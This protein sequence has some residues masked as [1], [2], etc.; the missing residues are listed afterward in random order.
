MT[1]CCGK[2]KIENLRQDAE[3]VDPA[4]QIK[5]VVENGEQGKD[6][7][8]SE[9]LTAWIW[10]WLCA[11]IMSLPFLAWMARILGRP[12]RRSAGPNIIDT[13]AAQC[14]TDGSSSGGE[15]ASTVRASAP[16]TAR[17]EL[18]P[19]LELSTTPRSVSHSIFVS[20]DVRSSMARQSTGRRK[21][22]SSGWIQTAGPGKYNRTDS[23]RRYL[24]WSDDKN[25]RG[26]GGKKCLSRHTERLWFKHMRNQYRSRRN[27]MAAAVG[28]RKVMPSTPRHLHRSDHCHPGME[29]RTSTSSADAE[30][31]RQLVH[32]QRDIRQR[33]RRHAAIALSNLMASLDLSETSSHA[34]SPQK[35]AGINPTA[36]AN[37]PKER[38]LSEAVPLPEHEA[39]GTPRHGELSDLKVGPECT[40]TIVV[41]TSFEESPRPT[42]SVPNSKLD[43]ALELESSRW[44]VAQKWWQEQ[45]VKAD[46]VAM[47][48]SQDTE[49]DSIKCCQCS[50]A[51]ATQSGLSRHVKL[52]HR[53]Q[54]RLWDCD[55]CH[56]VFPTEVG[57]DRHWN[58]VHADDLVDENPEGLPRDS[59]WNPTLRMIQLESMSRRDGDVKF[60]PLS[61]DLPFWSRDEW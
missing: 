52:L 31:H 58:A 7:Q 19:R 9:E 1:Q 24:R 27:G 40:R 6:V 36:T 5:V 60:G 43:T 21:L 42:K 30:H 53:R 54:T 23:R 50:R 14:R 55:I 18:F 22:G 20:R 44:D 12:V 28:P 8:E 26:K 35:D 4:S 13:S 16:G 33:Q 29:S 48:E 56:S 15:S 59:K 34:V 39:D 51:F 3:E 10:A 57:R 37:R 11:A 47:P 41:A 61:D 32:K 38:R 45:Q 49:Q 46:I 25:K 17:I 2:S